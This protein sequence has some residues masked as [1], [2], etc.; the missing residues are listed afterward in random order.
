MAGRFPGRPLLFGL[1]LQQRY[2]ASQSVT[3][4]QARTSVVLVDGPPV[5]VELFSQHQQR[6]GFSER[7]VFAA[8][9]A[10]KFLY[11]F[12]VFARLLTVFFLLGLFRLLAR[13]ERVSPRVDLL[14]I[15][16]FAAT[17]LAQVDLG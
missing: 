2:L 11:A 14:G 6:R 13:D 16:A 5:V 15:K 3:G 9:F 12:L 8:Q 17:I 1:P 10:L 7:L 4:A